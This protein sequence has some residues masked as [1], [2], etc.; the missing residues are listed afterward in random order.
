MCRRGVAHRGRIREVLPERGTEIQHFHEG[1]NIVENNDWQTREEG[2]FFF[3]L[4]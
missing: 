4:L 3:F 2:E 1:L